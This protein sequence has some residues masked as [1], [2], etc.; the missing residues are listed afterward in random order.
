MKKYIILAGL[1]VIAVVVALWSTNRMS[2]SV[3]Q[4]CTTE[5]KMCPD[6]SAVGRTGP[7]CEFAECPVTT[8]PVATSTTATLAI[9]DKVIVNA[10][11]VS[12]T[13][14]AEDS[15]CPVDVQCIQ[16]GT[17]RVNV[18]ADTEEVVFKLGESHVVAGMTM[19]FV[20]V[21]PA[22]KKSK[23]TVPPA[24]YRFTFTIEPK[25]IPI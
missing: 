22:Q 17:V 2:P 6:G 10:V 14:L 15:R 19:T 7:N 3:S 8:T 5:A 11:V 4:A 16:A 9:D 21:T 13:S 25:P 12:L 1:V 24:D 18:T 20:S 23:V